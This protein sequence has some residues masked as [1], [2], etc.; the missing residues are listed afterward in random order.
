MLSGW[1]DPTQAERNIEWTRK[2]HDAMRPSL[3]GGIYVNAVGADS[4]QLIRAAYRPETYDRLA[5][6]KGKYDPM[7]LFRLNPNIEPPESGERI[8]QLAGTGAQPLR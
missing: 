2:L 3:H 8:T 5:A 7:N 6:L 4:A 1:E